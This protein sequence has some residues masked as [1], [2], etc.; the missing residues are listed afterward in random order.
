MRDSIIPVTLTLSGIAV[1]LLLQ[2]VVVLCTSPATLKLERAFPHNDLMELSQLRDRDDLRHRRLLQQASTKDVIRFP[3]QGTYD[4]YRVGLYYS[5]VQL[6]SPPKEYYVQVDTGSDILWVNCKDCKGCPTSS[7]L[8][9]P[10]VLYDPSSSSTSSLISCSDKRCSIGIHSGDADCSDSNNWC[11]YS[12]KYGDGSA[13]SGYYVS[14]L[15]H[16]EMMSD[17][18][19]PSSNASSTVM[20]GCS[21]FQ[22]GELS[23]S[24]RAVDG[25]LGFGQQGLSVI[26]QLASQGAAPDAFSHCLV[27]DGDGGG[28]LVLGQIMDPNMVYSP[29]VPSQQH[30]NLHLQSISVN[31]KT[32]SIDPSVFETSHNRKGTVIDSGTTLGYLAEEAYNPFVN[33]ITKA[34]PQSVQPFDAKGYQCYVTKNSVSEVFPIVSFNFAGDASMVLKPENYLLK[35]KT[36][37][38]ET[39]WCIGFQKVK[40]R[41]LTILGD[42]VLKDKSV[43]YDLGGQRIGWVDHDC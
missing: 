30:Y 11:S 17:N 33:A 14:D 7:G 25:I 36:V 13:T 19:N 41:G 10:V 1:A 39:A 40:G 21:T 18:S 6:G 28:I 16:L 22:A 4:P 12:F 35:Q 3:L 32:L 27:G 5:K 31:D 24:D 9:I 2:G 37:G 34:V 29:L 20:F 26:S 42:V 43:V 15:I 23:M 8:K 38:G